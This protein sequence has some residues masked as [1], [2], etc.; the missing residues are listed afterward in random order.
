MNEDELPIII[1]S[2][3]TTWN[4]VVLAIQETEP[5]GWL[6]HCAVTNTVTHEVRE[7][8]VF[9]HKGKRPGHCLWRERVERKLPVADEW[10][11]TPHSLT[12]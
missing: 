4:F 2:P 9:L 1:S 8:I 3:R 10:H 6:A 12:S 7:Q 11:L 5:D